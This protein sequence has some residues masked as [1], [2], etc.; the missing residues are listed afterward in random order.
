MEE[1]AGRTLSFKTH[2]MKTTFTLMNINLGKAAKIL[3]LV[4]IEGRIM[5]SFTANY[6]TLENTY[7]MHDVSVM[8]YHRISSCS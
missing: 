4:S 3:P 7:A 1:S 6:F 8:R 2:T 5:Q